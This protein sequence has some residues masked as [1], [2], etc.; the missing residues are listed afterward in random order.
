[1]S[2]FAG[3]F[4]GRAEYLGLGIPADTT[5]SLKQIY[6]DQDARF[7]K[8]IAPVIDDRIRELDSTEIVDR[9]KAESATAFDNVEA[10]TTRQMSRYGVQMTPAQLASFRRRVNLGDSLNRVKS[11]SDARI[12]QSERQTALAADLANKGQGLSNIGTQGL[13]N[14]AN[15]DAQRKIAGDQS[16]AAWHGQMVQ[17]GGSLASAALIAWALSDIRL[18]E[19]VEVIGSVGPF[20]KVKWDWNETAQDVFGL[21][22]SKIGVIA[23]EVGE[24]YPDLVRNF[25]GFS[26]VDY[27]GLVQRVGSS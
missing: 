5:T 9:A 20:A 27:P 1:M 17:T 12:S 23:Q 24:V 11:V 4:I 22:G 8:Y 3:R 15:R 26:A 14:A 6:R 18:K 21:E 13:V 7:N 10:D 25:H 19:N 2:D 16:D